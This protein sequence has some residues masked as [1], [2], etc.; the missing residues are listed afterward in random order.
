MS[1]YNYISKILAKRAFPSKTYWVPIISS[2]F[3]CGLNINRL[4]LI[5]TKQW[6]VFYT[7]NNFPIFDFNGNIS[8]YSSLAT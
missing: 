5:L 4:V 7:N 2:N 3:P 8:L 6:D 1:V